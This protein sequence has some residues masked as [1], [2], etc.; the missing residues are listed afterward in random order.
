MTTSVI[1][2]IGVVAVIL[3]QLVIFKALI[4]LGDIL[5]SMDRSLGNNFNI[6][7]T[8]KNQLSVN[9]NHLNASRFNKIDK[10]TEKLMI[11][12]YLKSKSINGVVSLPALVMRS[13]FNTFKSKRAWFP[14]EVKD[15]LGIFSRY[16]NIFYLLYPESVGNDEFELKLTNELGLVDITWCYENLSKHEK[17]FYRLKSGII[18]SSKERYDAELD[19]EMDKLK[20]SI[21][22]KPIDKNLKE[23]FDSV[24]LLESLISICK[25]PE[26]AFTVID[27]DIVNRLLYMGTEYKTMN[28]LYKYEDDEVT[29][30]FKSVSDNDETRKN[31]INLITEY[32]K[33]ISKL[34]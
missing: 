34:L 24:K 3:F 16:H 19:S 28:D 8:I 30:Y 32:N 21:N 17:K 25:D 22:N 9:M 7:E 13:D 20:Q 26:L 18:T 27:N 11:D 12:G 6:L 4:K 1:I 5:T 33:K 23:L 31:T 2:A 15:N 29:L 14:T 10:E